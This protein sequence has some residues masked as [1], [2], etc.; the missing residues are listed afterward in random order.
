MEPLFSEAGHSRT[1]SSKPWP[2]AE[3][4]LVCVLSTV[5]VSILIIAAEREREKGREGEGEREGERT[6]PAGAEVEGGLEPGT[7]SRGST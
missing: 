7:Q 1:R 5:F 4:S 3:H 2:S 6:C